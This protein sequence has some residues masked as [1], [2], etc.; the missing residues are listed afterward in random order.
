MIAMTLRVDKAGRVILPKSLRDRSG[1]HE[2]SAPELRETTEGLV[3]Q[4]EP[5]RPSLAREGPFLVHA[6]ALPRGYDKDPH[7]AP[8]VRL[9]EALGS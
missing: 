3:Q 9:L 8:A 1:L 5:H 7:H 2:G 4:P 6:G